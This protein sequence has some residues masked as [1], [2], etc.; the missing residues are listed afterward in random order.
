VYDAGGRRLPVREALPIAP[1]YPAPRW[2]YDPGSHHP[3]DWWP[4][5]LYAAGLPR[6]A[7]AT[8][9]AILI[10]GLVALAWSAPAA[11][12]SARREKRAE[13]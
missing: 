4:W 2:Y 3:L 6:R 5:Y 11:I 1:M 10:P 12:R 7:G 9:L 13:C 8:A